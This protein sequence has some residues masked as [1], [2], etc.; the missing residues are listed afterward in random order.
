[1]S[2][3][4]KVGDAVRITAEYLET[5]GRETSVLEVRLDSGVWC[6]RVG[7]ECPVD[8]DWCNEEEL[9]P[10]G[11][12]GPAAAALADCSTGGALLTAQAV[13]DEIPPDLH[14]R[15]LEIIAAARA[16][17][18]KREADTRRRRR[19]GGR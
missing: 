7:V 4:F 5:C 2:A 8:G 16:L 6:Y 14:P 11:E 1:M 9:S 13:L 17:V 10:I 3:R 12:I 19:V 18:A 15:A